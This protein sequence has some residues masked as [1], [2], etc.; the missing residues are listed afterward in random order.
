MDTTSDIKTGFQM[1]RDF[2]MAFGVAKFNLGESI[3]SRENVFKDNM[4]LVK[5]RFGLIS[6]EVAELSE[7]FIRKA[8]HQVRQDL[9]HT[10]EHL[11][12]TGLLRTDH[13]ST[14]DQHRLLPDQVG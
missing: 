2:N 6:E 1:V 10:K 8:I 4:S 9:R 5:F 3:N 12:R 14:Q 13:L 11:R 7:A